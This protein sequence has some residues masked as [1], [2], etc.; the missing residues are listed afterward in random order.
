MFTD[1]QVLKWCYYFLAAH[2]PRIGEM[3]EVLISKDAK[4]SA[5]QNTI[6]VSS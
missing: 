6:A 5:L 3:Q 4:L 1:S 2:D